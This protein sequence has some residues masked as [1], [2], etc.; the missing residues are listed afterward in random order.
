MGQNV[1]HVILFDTARTIKQISVSVFGT[2]LESRCEKGA[3]SMKTIR[4]IVSTICMRCVGMRI[5]PPY[6]CAVWA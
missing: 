4:V 3:V 1:D 2:V 6:V 5:T